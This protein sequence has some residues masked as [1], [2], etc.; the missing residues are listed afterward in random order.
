MLPRTILENEV[1]R[2]T[3]LQKEDS[4]HLIELAKDSSLWNYFPVD[5]SDR[6]SFLGWLDRRLEL[7]EQGEWLPYLVFSKRLSQYV[8]MTCYLN[9]DEKNQVIEIGGTWYG[10]KFHGTDVNPNCKM[11]MM[12]HAFETLSMQRVEYKTDV[13]NERSR[14]AIMKLGAK[15]DGILRSDRIVQGDRRRD[16]I[17]YSILAEEWPSV[18]NKLAVRIQS[19]Q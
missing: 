16:T 10:S 3:P 12:S 18:K 2:L 9:I 7:M 17:Y 19:F 13:L 6:D 1:V 11:L 5:L 4:K 8:G 15:Q 14:R